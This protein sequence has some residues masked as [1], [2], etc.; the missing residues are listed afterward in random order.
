MT[1][2]NQTVFQWIHQFTG[3]SVF[4]D[5][6]GIFFANYL[7]YFLVLGFLVLAAYE[8]GWRRKFYVFAEGT[9]AVILSR[10]LITEII[11]FFYHHERPFAFYNFTP[12]IS[13]SAYSF[14]S[15]HAAWFFALALAVWYAN[16]TW[17]V[18]FFILASLNGIARVYV[19]VH[20]PLDIIGGIVVG[21]ISALIVHRLFKS[22][23]EK[24][25]G[26]EPVQNIAA[27]PSQSSSQSAI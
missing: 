21:V 22:T 14:P 12:L 2:L 25:Y 7:P 27:P 5:D 20:W 4:L 15:G 13:E 1:A 3:R 17:G 24:L 6:L 19:G 9:I 16:R 11:R 18:W 26:P 10:G 23:R 8:K